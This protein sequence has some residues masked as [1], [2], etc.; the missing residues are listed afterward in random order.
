MKLILFLIII[1][2][3]SLITKAAALGL[4]FFDLF[5]ERQS[6]MLCSKQMDLVYFRSVEKT[7]QDI[8]CFS[9]HRI[10]IAVDG[11]YVVCLVICRIPVRIRHCSPYI[12]RRVCCTRLSIL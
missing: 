1:G 6:F 3:K 7:D 10:G 4:L 12:F 9:L 5:D 11:F 8:R 2:V